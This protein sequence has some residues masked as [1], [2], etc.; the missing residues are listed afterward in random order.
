[1]VNMNERNRIPLTVGVTGH[2]GLREQDRDILYR[3]VKSELAQLREKYPHTPVK[4]LC[5]LAAGADLLCADAAEELD[6]PLTAVLPLAVDNYRRDFGEADLAKL[7]H[8][9]ERAEAVFTAPA[10]EAELAEPNRDFLYRQA[11]IYIAEHSHVLLAL[12]DGQPDE[13]GCGTAAAVRFALEGDWQPVREMPVRSA[14]NILVIH[15]LTP[16]QEGSEGSAGEIRHLGNR[17]A[18]DTM[19][20]RTDEFNALAA[21]CTGHNAYDAADALSLGFARKY[22]RALYGLALAGTVLTLAYLLY[23]EVALNW[24]ILVCGAALVFASRLLRLTRKTACHRRFIE[25][26]ELAEAL[27]VQRYLRE[28][29]SSLE[30]QRLM[31]WTQRQET[32]WILCALCAVNTAPPPEKKTDVLIHWVDSQREYHRKAGGHTGAQQK[33]KEQILGAAMRISALV[34]LAALVYEL[35]FGGMLFSPL[36][37]LN[38]PETGR[39][40]IKIVL[41]TLSAATL[42]MAGYYGKMSLERV[43]ADH[44]KMEKF[45]AKAADRLARCGQNEQILETLVRE[46]LTENGNWSS[47]QRDNAPEMNV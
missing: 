39:I 27:R 5:S 47:Y 17:Q 3:G 16:R 9:L 43:T 30:V 34:Y 2:I 15:I 22:R 12:W 42:F 46:E 40:V 10:A 31:T 26:R 8:H 28:A 37:R 29:G 21:D 33:K 6:I 35:I 25:Y 38:D 7:N 18:W 20:A 24:M 45:Y 13:S 32:P 1:M 36:I 11:G 44:E 4:L 41:G 23:D 14:E 19:I